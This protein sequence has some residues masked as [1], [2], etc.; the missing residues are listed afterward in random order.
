MNTEIPLNEMKPI[1]PVI[2]Y[3]LQLDDLELKEDHIFS[4]LKDFDCVFTDCGRGAL[5]LISEYIGEGEVLIPDYSC[6][7]ISQGFPR[8]NMVLYPM[9][10]DFVPDPD[11]LERMITRATKMICVN[12]FCGR[13]QEDE[14]IRGLL[15]LKEK[16]DL[17]LLEDAT[18]SFLSSFQTFGDFC[19]TSLYKWFPVPAGAALYSRSPLPE[20]IKRPLRKRKEPSRAYAMVLK[21]MQIRGEEGIDEQ[22]QALTDRLFDAFEEENTAGTS[23]PVASI[24]DL[25]R[26]LLRCQSVSQCRQKR[27][28]NAAAFA[29]MLHYDRIRPV[30]KR[31][32]GDQEAL[33]CYPIFCRTMEERDALQRSLEQQKIYAPVY[34]RLKPPFGTF[35]ESREICGRVLCFPV[36]Q[37]YDLDDMQ[38]M[39]DAVN[40]WEET[41]EEI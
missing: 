30:W 12:N 2:Y 41:W 24:T 31:L 37:R 20:I 17:V 39:A 1:G 4:C 19:T 28:E 14:I 33:L 40:H 8:Q 10:E 23:L 35:R 26:F 3:D 9:G 21:A 15:R 25:D 18:Q 16:Y 5:R 11:L 34:W 13:L 22:V 7:A 6:N 29:G 27:A 38:R 32:P 36:D